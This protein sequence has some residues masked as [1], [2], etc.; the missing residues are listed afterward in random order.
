[1]SGLQL[2]AG[3][4]GERAAHPKQMTVGVEIPALMVSLSEPADSTAR[5]RI[6]IEVKTETTRKTVGTILT[7]APA[8]GADPN[9]VV[10][11]VSVPGAIGWFVDG[12]LEPGTGTTESEAIVDLASSMC[13]G[14]FGLTTLSAE[15][16]SSESSGFLIGRSTHLVSQVLPPAGAF[17]NQA[18][19]AV[20]SGTKSITFWVTYT[21]GAVGGFPAFR[22]QWS[23]GTETA[24]EAVED[25]GSLVVA[26]PFADVSFY[27]QTL[28]GPIPADGNPITYP[29]VFSIPDNTTSVRLIAA[30]RGVT[31]TPGTVAIALTGSG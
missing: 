15:I 19:S 2:R 29:L 27:E 8:S 4:L 25:L 26:Q 18:F 28:L 6:R 1:M 13:C 23:N 11:I 16:I 22:A 24:T 21:R 5:W 14:S 12:R 9:R 31:A 20:P 7:V 17:T 3:S 10:A 30:E